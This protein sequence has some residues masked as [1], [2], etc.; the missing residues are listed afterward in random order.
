MSA[1]AIAAAPALDSLQFFFSA[2]RSRTIEEIAA[3]VF[4]RHEAS[5]LFVANAAGPLL[6]LLRVLGA[7]ASIAT[8]MDWLNIRP[9]WAESPDYN[10]AGGC[11]GNC[12]QQEAEMRSRGINSFTAVH[13]A[14]A[15]H[16]FALMAGHHRSPRYNEAVIQYEGAGAINLRGRESEAIRAATEGLG[17]SNRFSNRQLAHAVAVTGKRPLPYTNPRTGER[18]TARLFETASGGYILDNPRHPAYSGGIVAVHAP[19]LTDYDNPGIV[20]LENG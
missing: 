17:Q 8:I 10:N 12:Q 19:G 15:N 1:G 4:T 13:R 5:G 7:A 11:T 9:R 2:P 3:E 6:V 14:P 16:N 20:G 18:S